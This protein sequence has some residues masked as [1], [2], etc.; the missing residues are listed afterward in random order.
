MILP[1]G[2]GSGSVG[3]HAVHGP[4]GLIVGVSTS[5]AILK[6]IGGGIGMLGVAWAT[7]ERP[8]AALDSA[9]DAIAVSVRTRSDMALFLV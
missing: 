1:R 2:G 7:E 3:E 4:T 5:G 6:L 9:I 8:R